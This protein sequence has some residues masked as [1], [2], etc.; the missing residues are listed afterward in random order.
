MEDESLFQPNFQQGSLFAVF[1]GHGSNYVSNYCKNN[2]ASLLDVT[3]KN[4]DSKEEIFK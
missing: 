3:F 1:D 2:F 4:N